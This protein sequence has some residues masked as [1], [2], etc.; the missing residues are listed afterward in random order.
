MTSRW[1]SQKIARRIGQAAPVCRDSASP[2]A[3]HDASLQYGAGGFRGQQPKKE[4]ELGRAL[5]PSLKKTATSIAR[6]MK[7]CPYDPITVK[8]V[9]LVHDI[10]YLEMA[11]KELT[12]S[13]LNEAKRSRLRTHVTIGAE[14]VKGLSEP[15]VFHDGILYH[16][17]RYDGSGYVHGLDGD[18]IPII[19]R[20]IA[21]ADV[22][23]ALLAERPHRK[24]FTLRAALQHLERMAQK[25]LDPELVEVVMQMHG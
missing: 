12:G 13:R 11:T 18:E 20:I 23:E 5:A 16:H 1:R 25:Q 15:Q 21:V 8:K 10:G 3:R 4:K 22:F 7:K 6:K 19:A 24:A 14:M 17:E 2:R 9:A